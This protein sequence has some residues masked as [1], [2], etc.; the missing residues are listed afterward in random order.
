[1]LTGHATVNGTSDAAVNRRPRRL[2]GRLSERKNPVNAQFERQ[3]AH[4]ESRQQQQQQHQRCI[5][6]TVIPINFYCD[7]QSCSPGE[8]GN[9]HPS[10]EP[11]SPE[12]SLE[13]SS[14]PPI[15]FLHFNVP[16]ESHRRWPD[17]S[18][19]LLEEKSSTSNSVPNSDFLV[20]SF[21]KSSVNARHAA[22][23][24][25]KK[26]SKKQKQ[27]CRK[28]TGR[29]EA[30]CRE[31]NGTAPAIEVGDCEDL[32]LSPKRVGDIVFEEKFSPNSSVKEASEEAPESE[33]D[34]EY[35]CCSCASVSSASYCDEIELPRST[36]SLFGQYTTDSE[37]TGSS[38]ETCYA[39]YSMN[40]SHDTNTLL[41]FR[42]DCGPDSREMTECCN[43]SS[44]VDKNWLE[45]SDYGSGSCSQDA[46]SRDNG[47]HAVH[48]CSDTGSDSGFHLVISR[49][50]ARKEKKMSLWKNASSFT[51]G[52]NE[53]YADCSSRQ[54]TRELNT[55]DWPNRQ[56]HVGGIQ[57]QH[58]TLKHLT[59][60]FTHKP[61]NVC[62][63][64]QNGV[65]SK[66]SKLGARLNCL[67]S[68]KTNSIGNSA[69]S[70]S[71]MHNFYSNRKVSDAVHSRESNP[72]DMTSNSSHE[73]MTLKSSEG[74]G[75]SES[76]KSTVHT[77]GP[78]LTQ[79]RVLQD[80]GRDTDAS[81]PIS[82]VSSPC[83]KSTPTD[84]VVGGATISC[85]EGNRSSQEYFDSGMHLVEMI[86]VVN[87][88]Y[89]AQ[90]AADVHFAAGYPI[91]NLESFIHS[92][93][94][95]ISPI[96]PV[97]RSNCSWGQNC[98]DSDFQHDASSVSLRS[99]WEWYEEP[100]CYGLEVRAESDLNC[101]TSCGS[102]SEFLA[103]F[104]PYLSAIQLFGWS[105]KNTNHGFGVQ[106]REVLKSS[107]TASSHPVPSKLH[108]PYAESNTCLSESSF[109]VEDHGELMFEYFEMEQPF[110]RPPLF[111]KIKELVSSANVSDHRVLG[112]PEKLQNVKLRDLHPASW[113]CVAWYPVY[114][115]P[116]AN[117]RAAFL[118]YHS[119]GKLVPQK[120]SPDMTI[121]YN[122]IVSPVVG[123]QSYNDKG[124]QWFQMRCS[125]F[126]L[127]PSD[128]ASKTSRAEV[129]K[130][131]LRTLKMG[132]LA[133]SR[134]V[135]PNRIGK[136]V[137]HHPDYEFFL[138]RC[139]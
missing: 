113:Y 24:K 85:V 27:R 87:D 36:T 5:V 119:L 16:D 32:A 104:V 50:R 126:K 8:N 14:S 9:I 123:L 1:M 135:F 52:R 38:Q 3:V 131:R 58:V 136:S 19:R 134:A 54:M 49:K 125:D 70:F 111:E 68:P 106:G 103:Y 94:P 127:S 77:I 44:G 47:F 46:S 73:Q 34:N 37:F 84:S 110:F 33:N 23:R 12:G 138:S 48:V 96:P 31:S 35:H 79:K 29:S 122:R 51:H 71:K 65:P 30:K 18:S 17:N 64:T 114:R 26:K 63:E 53:K 112:D 57:T 95:A 90:V 129:L 78:L 117:F 121:E 124:E 76:G 107:S 25:S 132:A 105:R 6:L 56:S 88:A 137:N 89:R 13:P 7:F 120:C 97:R 28:P 10:S 40:Y 2:F 100:G 42:D 75:I 39:G 108:K 92:A 115:V 98:R 21:T 69:S 99:I 20:N 62:T 41:N 93:T 66:D 74:N 11:T 55:E 130:E 15:L 81:D 102:S 22:R 133:M 91:T 45:K 116:R 118:T 59:K 83:F 109:F 43:F 82:G 101:K 128:D 80:L 67:P 60:N 61:S 86:K 139:T 4:F 72:C